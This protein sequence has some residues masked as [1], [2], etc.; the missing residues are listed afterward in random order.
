[1]TEQKEKTWEKRKKRKL[2]KT[3]TKKQQ[4]TKCDKIPTDGAVKYKNA[5][6]IRENMK[7]E[8]EKN[9]NQSRE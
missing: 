8:S 3:K 7:K 2:T 4:N 5:S 1:M 6:R 9:E